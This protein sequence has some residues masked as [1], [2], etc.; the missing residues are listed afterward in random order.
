[1][2]ISLGSKQDRRLAPEGG[3][4]IV[5][6]TE[7]DHSHFSKYRPIWG[8]RLPD[9][10][11]YKTR[12]GKALLQEANNL[13]PGIERAV[14]VTHVATPLTFKERGGRSG[15]AVA[16]CSWDYEDFRDYRPRELVRTPIRGLYMAGYQGF[17]AIFIGGIPTAIETGKRA[18]EAV[19]QKVD[20]A[21]TILTLYSDC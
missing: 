8:E 6:R 17:S 18:A 3:G 13:I 5:I 4:V 10:Y 7:A 19:L 14:L 9:Y 20:P 16:G 21:E 15:G 2:E 11:D 12:L 1:L